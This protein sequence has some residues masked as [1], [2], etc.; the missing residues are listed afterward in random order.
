MWNGTFVIQIYILL[1]LCSN[2]RI[3]VIE[4]LLSQNYSTYQITRAPFLP[5]VLSL[6]ICV[7]WTLKI[8]HS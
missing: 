3:L 7:V 8:C 4:E 1:E 2:A 6:C 5:I